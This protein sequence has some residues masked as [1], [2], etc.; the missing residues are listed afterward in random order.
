MPGRLN[1]EVTCAVCPTRFHPWPR[2]GRQQP[3]TCSHACKGVLYRRTLVGRAMP[4]A[5]AAMA[6]IRANESRWLNE[7]F[8]ATL[9]A[10]ELEIWRHGVKVGRDRLRRERRREAA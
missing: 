6:T 10:R 4:A 3:P 5:L 9:T 2:K 8:G 1:I 7:R